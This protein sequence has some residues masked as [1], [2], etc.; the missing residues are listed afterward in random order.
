MVISK[1]I[2]KLGRTM[3]REIEKV[4]DLLN[5]DGTLKNNGFSRKMLLK[6][7][8]EQIR[9]KKRIREWD[10]YVIS[11][12]RYNLTLKIANYGKVACLFA[13][14]VDMFDES[15]AVNSSRVYFPKAKQFMAETSFRGKTSFETKNASFSFEVANGK[16]ILKGNF[17]NF[18]EKD[19]IKSDLTFDI[20]VDDIRQ[21]GVAKTFLFKNKNQFCYT[22]NI[23]CM[24]AS[25]VFSFKGKQIELGTNAMA[26][27]DWGRG[28]MPRKTIRYWAA[29]QA[30]V[31]GH[32][33]GINLGVMRGDKADA[34]QNMIFLD[35]VG[36]KVENLR[37]FVRRENK[38]REYL[39]SWTFYSS[40][41]KV[42]LIFQPSVDVKAPKHGWFML[43]D[44]HHVFGRFT[45]TLI[46]EDG[47]RI[48]IKDLNGFAERTSV[49][50]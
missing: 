38:K 2:R 44:S 5:A 20:V 6:Y 27:L 39:R 34:S 23:T 43:S 30:E 48:K 40:D 13:S 17:K 21:D 32:T 4:D 9:K 8:K 24:P 26:T 28:V 22:H 16:R 50:W 49:L 3:Q 11:D 37:V 35:G 45:G 7:N 25:G 10:K 14:V 1:I 42:E 29:L 19:G 41:G 15:G 33:I 36:H 47:S 46:L 18:F 12:Y 31:G